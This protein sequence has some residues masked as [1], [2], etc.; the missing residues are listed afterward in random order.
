M[1]CETRFHRC[2]PWS[3]GVKRGDGGIIGWMV[4]NGGV[5]RRSWVGWLCREGG[6]GNGDGDGE[7][8]CADGFMM[9][10]SV[11]RLSRARASRLVGVS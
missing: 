11:G 4:G 3:V 2:E 7:G 6:V 1:G 10:D 9:G 5:A 8:W